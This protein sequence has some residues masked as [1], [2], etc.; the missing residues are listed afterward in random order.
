MADAK[1]KEIFQQSTHFNPVDLICGTKDYKGEKFD[2]QQY[3]DPNQAF[4]TSKT[5][6]GRPLKALELPGLWNGSMAHWITLFVEVPIITFNPV[7]VV[8]DLLKKTHQGWGAGVRGQVSGG[9]FQVV[10]FRTQAIGKASTGY[11]SNWQNW[12][13]E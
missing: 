12:K 13:N 9:R 5:Y 10:G 4:I 2:L 6:M 11:V 7:K 1:Q 3:V 8:N